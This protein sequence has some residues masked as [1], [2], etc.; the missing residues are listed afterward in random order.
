VRQH[1][2]ASNSPA[3]SVKATTNS[4]HF[5]Q[6]QLLTRGDAGEMCSESGSEASTSE[7]RKIQDFYSTAGRF[8]NGTKWFLISKW[9]I[10]A[11]VS[12]LPS[13]AFSALRY[14]DM[15]LGLPI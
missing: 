4:E 6:K 7:A 15:A 5:T 10:P 13:F 14:V 2:R 8:H 3:A 9:H 12:H 1:S 11:A